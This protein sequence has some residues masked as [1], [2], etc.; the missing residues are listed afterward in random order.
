[1]PAAF[2]DFPIG[3][4]YNIDRIVRKWRFSMSLKEQL[5]LTG[6]CVLGRMGLVFNT[7]MRIHNRYR[8]GRPGG[9]PLHPIS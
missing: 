8:A 9:R 5:L 7:L 4:C 1:M 2:I 3:K 6:A